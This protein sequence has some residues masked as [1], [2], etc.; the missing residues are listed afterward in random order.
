MTRHVASFPAAALAA[1]CLTLLAS[2]APAATEGRLRVEVLVDGRT[3]AEHR[4]RG[5]TYV[6]ALRGREYAIRLTNLEPVR[7]AV[8]LAV[9]GRNSIDGKRTSTGDARK[10]ILDPWQTV[11]ISGWQTGED[12]ARRFTF[13]TTERSYAAW[14]GDTSNVGV[15]EAVAFREREPDPPVAWWG[16]NRGY[17]D[18][19]SARERDLDREE[20]D[21]RWDRPMEKSAPGRGASQPASPAPSAQAGSMGDSASSAGETRSAAKSQAHRDNSDRDEAA[22]GMGRDVRNDVMRV[23]FDAERSP[24]SSVRI[25]YEYREALVALGVL[26]RYEPRDRYDR[27]EHASG[28]N[29]SWCPE[30][31]RY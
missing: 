11:V 15:I 13:T 31:P 29:D 7:V 3:Q 14:L 23:A 28:F 1:A 12:R 6:E 18:G 25:R 10:W 19:G 20:N 2:A 27:R 9:D 4:S 24:S 26:P 17:D 22:T 30:P 5:T 21:G 8:A 16:R